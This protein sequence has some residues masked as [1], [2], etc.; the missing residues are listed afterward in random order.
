[1]LRPG[2]IF[3]NLVERIEHFG[4]RFLTTL[5]LGSARLNLLSQRGIAGHDSCKALAW[6]PDGGI[7]LLWNILIHHAAR[8]GPRISSGP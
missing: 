6:Q 5:D 4:H 1:M 2:L 3:R 8:G 7:D